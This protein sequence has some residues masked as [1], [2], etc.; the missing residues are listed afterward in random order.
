M[1]YR[2]IYTEVWR[3][4]WFLNLESDGKLLYIYLFS[5]ER[6]NVLGLYEI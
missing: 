4:P 5:N 3:D 2:Q 1:I 6:T